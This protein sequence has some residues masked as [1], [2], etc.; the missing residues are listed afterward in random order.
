[1]SAKLPV[2]TTPVVLDHINY[3]MD[4]LNFEVKVKEQMAAIIM[5]LND[6]SSDQ[7]KQIL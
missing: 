6:R 2:D 3:E 5:P 7:E 4:Q 1:M